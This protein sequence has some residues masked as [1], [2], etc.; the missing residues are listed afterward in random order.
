MPYRRIPPKKWH[1]RDE[2]RRLARQSTGAAMKK[3]V[4]LVESNSDFVSVLAA[5]A[6]LQRAEVEPPYR[7]PKTSRARE[8]KKLAAVKVKIT[9]FSKGEDDAG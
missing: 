2:V 7:A 6:V 9:R 5:R 8:R 1:A 3:L 4:T